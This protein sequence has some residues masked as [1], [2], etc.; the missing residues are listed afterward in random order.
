MKHLIV[1]TIFTFVILFPIFASNAQAACSSP[2]GVASQTR[3]DFTAHKMYYCDN[4]NWVEMGGSGGGGGDDLYL[5]QHSSTQC[6]AIG[7]TVY[8]DGGDK[9]CRFAGS[10]CP[11]GWAQAKN[12]TS[13]SNKRCQANSCPACNTGGHGWNNIARETCTYR[14]EDADDRCNINRTCTANMSEIGCY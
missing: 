4:T 9:V 7:G 8:N 2:T 6:T 1:K 11:P 5:Q 14:Q 3:Y 12:W 13:T 10:S